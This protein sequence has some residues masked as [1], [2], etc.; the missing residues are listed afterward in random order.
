MAGTALY[1]T[2][3]KYLDCQRL[4]RPPPPPTPHPG[5]S[6]HC[7]TRASEH[8]HLLVPLVICTQSCCAYLTRGCEERGSGKQGQA[9]RIWAQTVCPFGGVQGLQLFQAQHALSRIFPG[10]SG[11]PRHSGHGVCALTGLCSV[12]GAC[13]LPSL[14]QEEECGGTAPRMNVRVK[15]VQHP[16]SPSQGFCVNYLATFPARRS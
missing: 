12:L 5:H 8:K 2:K 13:V 10:H 14:M 15:S 9:R 3:R 16:V 6:Q 1:R 4:D 11:G 7:R